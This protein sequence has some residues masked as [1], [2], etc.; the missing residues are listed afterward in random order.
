MLIR[1]DPEANAAYITLGEKE[2]E[3]GAA[4]SQ[5]DLIRTPSGFGSVILDFAADG[6]LIGVEVLAAR[7]LLDPALLVP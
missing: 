3:P 4:V 5:S 2:I 1:F 6:R 7:E